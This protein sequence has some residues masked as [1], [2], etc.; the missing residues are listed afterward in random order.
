MAAATDVD[1][2]D[3]LDDID[4]DIDDFDVIQALDFDLLAD[5]DREF[6]GG[7]AYYSAIFSDADIVRHFRHGCE[8]GDGD[9]DSGAAATC[10]W[11]LAGLG[12]D[13][14]CGDGAE[15]EE[16]G[17]SSSADSGI[18][19]DGPLAPAA[20]DDADAEAMSAYVAELE[21]FL[22]DDDE[23]PEVDESLLGVV[24]DYFAGDQ[25]LATAEVVPAAGGAA[26]R[27][28]G[29]EEEEEE[30]GDGG[31]DVL[32]AREDEQSDSRKRARYE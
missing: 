24:D 30:K 5:D 19:Y 8:D 1:L 2:V 18:T 7:G 13:D 20:G 11:L 31:E 27:T 29:E 28:E 16:A 3:D 23:Q 17:S 6:R 22:L 25:L 14:D 32:A 26:G 15:E 4:I 9:G 12:D 10:G 21:R